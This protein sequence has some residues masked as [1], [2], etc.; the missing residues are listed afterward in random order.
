MFF[1]RCLLSLQYRSCRYSS[2]MSGR[3]I[4]RRLLR[5]GFDVLKLSTI[6]RIVVKKQSNV[7]VP[8]VCYIHASF[9]RIAIGVSVSIGNYWYRG[10]IIYISAWGLYVARFDYEGHVERPQNVKRAIVQGFTLFLCL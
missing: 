8:W 7:N 10:R 3:H 1:A 5:F 6:N 9:Y 4:E 2:Y